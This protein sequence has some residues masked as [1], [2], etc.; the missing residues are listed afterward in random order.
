[1]SN[2]SLSA[3]QIL[4]GLGTQCLGR[5]VLW[6]PQVDSTNSAAKTLAAQ[7]EP[8][9]T[10]VIAEEQTAGRGRHGRAWLAPA[11][12]GL[13]FSIILRPKLRP[14]HVQALTMITAL[15]LRDALADATALR[16]EIKWPN[17]LLL[18]GRKVAGILCEARTTG[19]RVDFAILGIGLN[20]NLPEGALPPAFSAT[21]LAL[22]LGHPVPR[23]PLLRTILRRLDQRYQLLQ[24][25]QSPT[26]EWAAALATLGLRV[27]VI[28]EDQS[29]LGLAETV[30]DSGALLLRLDDGQLIHLPAGDVHP[31]VS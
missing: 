3:E 10:V 22:E 1:M 2:G 6:Y 5:R 28:H 24:A 7:G 27:Q 31:V 18:S 12:S 29:Y 23:A 15:A 30:D 8:E 14:D 17:D 21:S 20:V 13:L 9:G 11:S 26:A 25:G 4:D 19:A 16:A